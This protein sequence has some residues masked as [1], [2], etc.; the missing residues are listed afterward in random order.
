MDLN[1]V[2]KKT[3]SLEEV[4]EIDF[5][6]AAIPQA[7]TTE[8]TID[9]KRIIQI[10]NNNIIAGCKE[11]THNVN[12]VLIQLI[13]DVI[14]KIERALPDIYYKMKVAEKVKNI[15]ESEELLPC[16]SQCTHLKTVLFTTI[17]YEFIKTW[18][19]FVNNILCRKIEIN[20][21]NYIYNVAKH[22]SKK[23]MKKA[24]ENKE[25]NKIKI[26]IYLI[27]LDDMT[28]VNKTYIYVCS[29]S[30]NE[31]KALSSTWHN[32]IYSDNLQ[33]NPA[34]DP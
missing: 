25:K 9:P 16:L 10:V 15:L 24:S 34:T 3:N 23:Y 14:E 29:N 19:K 4:E 31:F 32:V 26:K 17:A 2:A 22:M 5:T 21:D 33:K 11:C 6:E 28:D 13:Q 27:V 30:F 18:C 7:I 8:I 20:S 12:N 1:E